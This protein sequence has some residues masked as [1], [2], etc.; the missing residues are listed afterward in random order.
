MSGEPIAKGEGKSVPE[1]PGWLGWPSVGGEWLQVGSADFPVGLVAQTTWTPE[2]IR[3][4]AGRNAR[5]TADKNVCATVVWRRQ[6]D[7]PW[8]ATAKC[9]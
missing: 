9:L 1:G 6:A 8:F 2:S 5:A 3:R 7:L 4:R